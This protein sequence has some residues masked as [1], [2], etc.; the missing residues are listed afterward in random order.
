M[1]PELNKRVGAARAEVETLSRVWNHALFPKSKKV[2][3]CAACVISTILYCLHTA[4]LN[5]AEL[6]RLNAF[7]SKCFRKILRIPH[8]YVS[9]ISNK[10]VLER[11]GRNKIS[12]MLPYRQLILCGKIASLTSGSTA[13]F[14]VTLFGHGLLNSHARPKNPQGSNVYKLASDVV[15]G[16]DLDEALFSNLK[17]WKILARTLYFAERQWSVCV[18]CPCVIDEMKGNEMK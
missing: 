6:R 3:I 10:T 1:E 5:Q 17:Q 13:C 18:P 14:L 15:G 12:N 11:S 8:S 7:Q 16:A 9:R 4:W 2:R